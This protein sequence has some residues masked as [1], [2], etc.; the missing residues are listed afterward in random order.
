AHPVASY[1]Q[2]TAPG[3]VNASSSPLLGKKPSQA[4]G[5]FRLRWKESRALHREGTVGGVVEARA[6]RL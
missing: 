6:W 2:R 3:V 1:R 5:A 4:T